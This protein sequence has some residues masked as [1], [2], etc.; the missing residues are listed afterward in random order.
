V[1]LKKELEREETRRNELEISRKHQHHGR[2]LRKWWRRVPV[3][4]GEG[5]IAAHGEGMRTLYTVIML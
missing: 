4:D 1:A 2:T 5:L 3:A